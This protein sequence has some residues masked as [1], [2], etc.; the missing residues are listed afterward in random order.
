MRDNKSE[1]IISVA[2]KLIRQK[3]FKETTFQEIA[4]K[5]GLHKSSLYHYFKHKEE[6]LLRILGKSVDQVDINLEKII[7]DNQ[8][9]PEGKLR[10]AI[11]NHLILLISN[12]DSVNIYLNELR[13]LSKKNRVIYLGKRKKY[14]EDFEKIFIEMKA[15]GYFKGL[16]P[17]IL[18]FGMLGML[19]WVP[20]WYKNHGP[21]DT[22][23]IS[24]IF[25]RMIVRK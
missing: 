22:K 10:K 18:T 17:K 12:I 16:H 9:G 21:L 4:D 19:N 20:R 13:N 8:L 2:A 7:M 25:Y 11:E 14:R 3:N 6:L 24:D 15:K 23:E 1:K 5:V